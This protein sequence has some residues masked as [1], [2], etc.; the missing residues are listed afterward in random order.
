M[1][2]FLSKKWWYIFLKCKKGVSFVD[3]HSF[4]FGEFVDGES[5]VW[6]HFYDLDFKKYLNFTIPFAFIWVY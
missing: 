2:E 3:L 4:G 1:G 6:L 5:E